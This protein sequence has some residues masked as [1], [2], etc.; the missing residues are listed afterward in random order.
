MD[1]PP[2][3]CSVCARPD[4]HSLLVPDRHEGDAWEAR[5]FCP[6]CLD[7]MLAV[8]PL[9]PRRFLR[10][11]LTGAWRSGARRGDPPRR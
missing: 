1:L 4:A 10:R 11:E 2:P 7:A 5:P 3:D 8:F 9:H 6:L